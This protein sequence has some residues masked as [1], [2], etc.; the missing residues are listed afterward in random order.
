MLDRK[1]DEF[2]RLRV[3]Y[4]KVFFRTVCLVATIRT[5]NGWTPNEGHAAGVKITNKTTSFEYIGKLV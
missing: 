1:N 5:I 2:A 4:Q 3:T